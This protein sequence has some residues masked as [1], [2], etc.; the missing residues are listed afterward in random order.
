MF[1]A[2]SNKIKYPLAAI[3]IKADFFGQSDSVFIMYVV[4]HPD[5]KHLIAGHIHFD[6]SLNTFS[7]KSFKLHK[8]SLLFYLMKGEGH[9]HVN[10][11][12]SKF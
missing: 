6:L 11:W 12:D 10:F 2:S 5:G 1:P 7:S 3:F 8:Y 4:V 9:I